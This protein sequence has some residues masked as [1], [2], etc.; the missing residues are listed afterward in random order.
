MA[1]ETPTSSMDTENVT[2]T[3]M[4]RKGAKTHKPDLY[5]GVRNHTNIWLLQLDLYFYEEDME[6]DNEDKVLFAASYMRGDTGEW[7]QPYVTKYLDINDDNV[8]P[9]YV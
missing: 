7:I 3:L 6:K 8:D 2:V 1:T 9:I 5:Y 4:E